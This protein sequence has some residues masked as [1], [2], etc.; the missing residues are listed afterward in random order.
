MNQ[1]FTFSY[2][3]LRKLATKYQIP[4]RS[5]MK[6]RQACEIREHYYGE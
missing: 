6:S 3:D 2:N 1:I 5:T 4:G